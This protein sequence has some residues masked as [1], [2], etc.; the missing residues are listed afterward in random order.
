MLTFPIEVIF[1]F[2]KF[3]TMFFVMLGPGEGLPELTEF[4]LKISDAFTNNAIITIPAYL[5]F[6]LGCA[7]LVGFQCFFLPRPV[8]IAITVIFFLL[9]AG[10]LIIGPAYAM[11]L[12]FIK[13]TDKLGY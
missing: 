7:G 11:Y 1:I 5:I 12:P 9:G 10:C 4:V 8:W 6:S 3:K 13:M 2:P